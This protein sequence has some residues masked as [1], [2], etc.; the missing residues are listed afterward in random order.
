MI[1]P[2]IRAEIKVNTKAVVS[3]KIF[4][5]KGINTTI[6]LIGIIVKANYYHWFNLLVTW[7]TK[8]IL[9]MKLATYQ[10]IGR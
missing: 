4:E 2:R 7:A 1:D 5:Y 8:V 3:S 6:I 10:T 9:L